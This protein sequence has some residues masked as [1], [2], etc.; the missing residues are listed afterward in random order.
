MQAPT[1]PPLPKDLSPREAALQTGL[2]RTLIYR[3]VDRGNLSAYKVG[4]R[5]R[6]PAEALEDWKR[7]HAVVARE[8]P[9]Y[10]PARP[11]RMREPSGFARELRAIR[12]GRAA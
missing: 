12:A 7:K 4:G 3:E 2:S 10:E 1:S 5:L 8:A 9:P 6:I 11:G